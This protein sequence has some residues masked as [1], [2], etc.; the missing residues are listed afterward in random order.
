[1][2]YRYLGNKTKLANWV[3]EIITNLVPQDSKIADPMCGTG[4]IS[5]ALAQKG[6]TV[7]AADILKF[8]T[9]HANARLLFD[10]EADFTPVGIS[11]YQSAID[12]LNNLSGTRGLFWGE[13]SAEGQPTNGSKPRCY[14]TGENA[15]KIDAIRR[16]IVSWRKLGLK[17]QYADLLLHD[18]I[19]A[20]NRV[21]N[22]TGTYGYYRSSWNRESLKPINL[23]A[24]QA[25]HFS[26]NKHKVFHGHIQNLV[27]QIN[28][29]EVCYLDPPYT[30][31]QYGGNYH[32]L[33]TIAQED[34]PEPRGDGGLRDWRPNAS[35]FCYKRKAP[36]AF[37]EILQSLTVPFIIV[38]YSTDGQIAPGD[39]FSLLSEYGNV[40]RHVTPFARF[41]SN[42]RGGEKKQL[43]EHLYIIERS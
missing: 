26:G 30:K 40:T 25:S 37:R 33:E 20:V 18:L 1:M 13:Y 5:E 3:V 41:D 43:Q 24:S 15:E 22:I 35:D 39:L 38:S 2:S 19:L 42:G 27:E 28:S 34:E 14:F 6:Y 11:S 29:C 32:I 10:G 7:L 31:R 17:D 36:G 4:A 16:E 21:A 12:K 8:P 9:L 23:I